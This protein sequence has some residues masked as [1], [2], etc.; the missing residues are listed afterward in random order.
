MNPGDRLLYKAK[1]LIRN[2]ALAEQ[3]LKVH[4]EC[5]Q[6]E[7]SELEADI[8]MLSLCLDW[9]DACMMDIGLQLNDLQN[10]LNEMKRQAEE[11]DDGEL[12][13]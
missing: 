4:A 6:G 7:I 2:D 8:K 13:E 1:S 5:T 3:I 9:H 11:N 12:P 10:E